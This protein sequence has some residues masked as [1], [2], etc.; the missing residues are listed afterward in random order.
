MKEKRKGGG[1]ETRNS[2]MEEIRNSGNLNDITRKGLNLKRTRIRKL[3][4]I[5]KSVT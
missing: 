2:R 1:K 5:E 3:L 4:G